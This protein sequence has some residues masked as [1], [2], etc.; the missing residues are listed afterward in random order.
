MLLL[1]SFS[2]IF[3]LET[4]F[5]K[6]VTFFFVWTS[7]WSCCRSGLFSRAIQKHLFRNYCVR[8][9]SHINKLRTNSNSECWLCIV[10]ILTGTTMKILMFQANIIWIASQFWNWRNLFLQEQQWSSHTKF[11]FFLNQIIPIKVLSI[12]KCAAFSQFFYQ[13][14]NNRMCFFIHRRQNQHPHKKQI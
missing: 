8:K 12:F 7:S 11:L 6:I 9:I 14:C 5:F 13:S 1:F 2:L 3:L 4:H 10:F